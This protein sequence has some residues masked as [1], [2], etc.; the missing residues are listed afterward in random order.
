MTMTKQILTCLAFRCSFPRVQTLRRTLLHWKRSHKLEAT[1]CNMFTVSSRYEGNGYPRYAGNRRLRGTRPSGPGCGDTSKAQASGNTRLRCPFRLGHRGPNSRDGDG[2]MY[3]HAYV[4]AWCRVPHCTVRASPPVIV[5]A[6]TV[7]A[8][9]PVAV[10]F[11][12][13]VK[14]QTGGQV[15]AP[16]CAR[17]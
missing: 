10:V 6:D 15:V 2:S 5:G 3:S 8:G 11:R 17:L 7:L 12:Q 14:T 13:S 9:G 4:R 16:G 1:P